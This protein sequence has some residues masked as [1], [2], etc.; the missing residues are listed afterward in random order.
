MSLKT[1]HTKLY[2]KSS[3]K[4][5]LSKVENAIDQARADI[6]LLKLDLQDFY[7]NNSAALEMLQGMQEH[8]LRTNQGFHMMGNVVL[9]LEE[10]G[11]D[12]LD[13]QDLKHKYDMLEQLYGETETEIINAMQYEVDAA[14]QIDDFHERFYNAE[15]QV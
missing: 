15:S 14:K 1:I 5:T 6:E 13:I 7:V 8:I 10:L 11:I 12:E 9:E 2:K 3:K 4:V